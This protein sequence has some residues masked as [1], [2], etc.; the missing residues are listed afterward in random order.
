MILVIGARG[1]EVAMIGLADPVTLGPAPDGVESVFPLSASGPCQTRQE[2]NALA[3]AKAAAVVEQIMK[4]S[5][6][7]ADE[8]LTPIAR[9]QRPVEEALETSAV[10]WTFPASKPVT[11]N[12]AAWPYVDVVAALSVHQS[13]IGVV[14]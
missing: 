10:A 5:V 13:T 9:K 12:A 8:L 6:W 7:E 11:A 2:V 3:A 1:A 14:R 4:L